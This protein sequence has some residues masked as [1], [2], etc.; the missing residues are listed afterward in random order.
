MDDA[1]VVIFLPFPKIVLTIEVQTSKVYA[2]H[3]TT[4]HTHTNGKKSFKIPNVQ[5]K[6]DKNKPCVG[7]SVSKYLSSCIDSITNQNNNTA[8]NSLFVIC[9]HGLNRRKHTQTHT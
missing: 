5:N 4:Y 2:H 6:T 3:L 8:N 9:K 7:L 1:H